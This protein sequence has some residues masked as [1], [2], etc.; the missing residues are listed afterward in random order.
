MKQTRGRKQAGEALPLSPDLAARSTQKDR[1]Y[2]E[3]RQA[4]M[5]GEFVPALTVT[6]RSLAERFQAG[7]M[8]VRDAVQRLVAERALELRPN[9]RLRVPCLSPGEIRSLMDLRLLLEGYDASCAAENATAEAIAE[10]SPAMLRLELAEDEGLSGPALLAANFRFHF[11][12]YAAA[13]SAQLTRMIEALWLQFG[14][15]LI[16][17][18]NRPDSI[19]YIEDEHRLHRRLLNAI[20]LGDPKFAGSA[21]RAII[22]RTRAAVLGDEPLLH[23]R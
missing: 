13:Q 8:P 1:V 3:L 7:I 22:E 5:Y 11:S 21:M 2:L 4:L 19:I 17:L 18:M 20:E 9:G 14:P 6:V 16:D 10:V 23:L 15:L 12:V